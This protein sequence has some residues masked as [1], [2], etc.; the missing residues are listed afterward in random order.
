[1]PCWI[2]EE[3]RLHNPQIGSRASLVYCGELSRHRLFVSGT[4]RPIGQSGSLL[5]RSHHVMTGRHVG[6]RPPVGPDR[7]T[8]RGIEGPGPEP[9]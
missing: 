1:M 6:V 9:G 7:L 8:A 4:A 2:D 3:A 5:T